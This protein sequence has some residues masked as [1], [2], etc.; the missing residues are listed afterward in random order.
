M[1]PPEPVGDEQP[2]NVQP[3]TNTSELESA[4]RHAPLTSGPAVTLTNAELYKSIGEPVTEMAGPLSG[5]LCTVMFCRHDGFCCVLS[6]NNWPILF[7]TRQFQAVN[8]DCDG[9]TT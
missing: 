5:Q 1:A 4:L 2:A 3:D 9:P 8:I 6:P 7:V